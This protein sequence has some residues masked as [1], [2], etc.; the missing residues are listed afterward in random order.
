[1]KVP[2]KDWEVLAAG[3]LLIMNY[4]NDDGKRFSPG[5]QLKMIRSLCENFQPPQGHSGY[6]TNLADVKAK[7]ARD[8]LTL[9]VEPT[10]QEEV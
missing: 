6:L 5:H 7:A 2:T 4:R 8:G 1:M 3:V 9:V 10:K